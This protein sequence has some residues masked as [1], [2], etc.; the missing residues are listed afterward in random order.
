MTKE[1][2]CQFTVEE[3]QALLRVVVAKA[4]HTAMHENWLYECEGLQT[5]VFDQVWAQLGPSDKELEDFENHVC[6][7]KKKKPAKK[8]V[9]VVSKS[10]KLPK[11]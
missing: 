4:V 9:P 1:M 3:L 5:K 6:K 11:K 8:K 2:V 10:K 7:P